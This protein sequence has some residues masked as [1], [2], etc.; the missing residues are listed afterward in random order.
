MLL[1]MH[2]SCCPSSWSVSCRCDPGVYIPHF[3]A[4][5]SQTLQHFLT[6]LLLLQ[7]SELGIYPA[8][9]PLD[10]TSRMLSPSVIGQEHYDVARGVQKV[11][12]DYKNLQD[13]IAILGMDELSEDDKLVVARAR[14]IQR[15]L[16]QPFFVAEVF[17]G[18]PGKYVELK[19]SIQG[20]KVRRLP[21]LCSIGA[22]FVLNSRSGG[23]RGPWLMVGQPMGLCCQSLCPVVR[24]I[25]GI[26]LYWISA[27]LFS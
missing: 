6:N 10:S 20:F 21:G 12:Q 24:C 23:H 5:A 22:P 14:K 18:S 25:R 27:G 26:I 3:I 2:T 11:L 15:F 4:S 19:E 17:T 7:I 1:L 8:V 13:I 16:S 9:D